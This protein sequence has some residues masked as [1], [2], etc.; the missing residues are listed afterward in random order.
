MVFVLNEFHFEFLS[1]VRH[2]FFD[3]DIQ[4]WQLQYLKSSPDYKDSYKLTITMLNNWFEK[5]IFLFKYVDLRNPYVFVM[6]LLLITMFHKNCGYTAVNKQHSN[7]YITS[8][9]AIW[10]SVC[11]VHLCTGNRKYVYSSKH[12]FA[13]WNLVLCK[14]PK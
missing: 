3:V 12:F 1:I 11:Y 7:T 13:K 8:L 9:N 14:F 4:L 6:A 2:K 5:I 10:N